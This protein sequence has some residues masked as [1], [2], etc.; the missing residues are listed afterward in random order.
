MRENDAA[1]QDLS[2]RCHKLLRAAG[3][4]LKILDPE[5]GDQELI[6]LVAAKMAKL[7]L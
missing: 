5:L 1:M 4:N 2:D 6:E 3:K 7:C